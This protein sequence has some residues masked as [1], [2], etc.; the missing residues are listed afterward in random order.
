MASGYS[1]PPPLPLEIH[2]TNASEKWKKFYRA[3]NSYIV[4]T[5][6]NKK[7]EAVQLATLLTVIGEEAREVFATFTWEA[8]GDDAKIGIV[9]D[10]FKSYCEPR[11]KIP[12]EHYRFNLRAQ[13]PGE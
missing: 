11:K 1:L 2:S 4:A 10:K 9:I 7:S 8:E 5:E 6:L 12:F 13:E 3:W